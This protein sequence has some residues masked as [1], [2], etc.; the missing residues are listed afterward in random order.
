MMD[1]F[2]TVI[3]YTT[4]EAKSEEVINA[5]FERMEEIEGIASIFDEQSQASRLNRDGYLESP[6]KDLRN[7]IDISLEYSQRTDGYF[8]I[9]VQPLLE[10]WESGLWMEPEDVQQNRVNETLKLVGPDKIMVEDD[11]ILL[12]EEGVK[13]TLGGIAKGYA[14]DEALKVIKSMGVKNALINAGGDMAAIGSKPRGEAWYIALVNPDDTSQSLANFDIINNAITTSGNY[15]RY[16]D[17]ERKAHHILNPK[18]GYPA[19]GIISVTVIADT[20]TQADAL[21]T[22]IFVMGPEAGIDLV[23]SLSNVECLIVSADRQTMYVSSG[24]SEYLVE[25]E[26]GE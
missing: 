15:E 18:T 7:L 11:R 2:I 13:I 24:L 22:S 20:A 1:T 23:E 4:D 5:A 8:D 21:S 6:S 19:Q 17:P 14:V 9:T 12:T 26:Q 3:V 16:F 25:S 10:L